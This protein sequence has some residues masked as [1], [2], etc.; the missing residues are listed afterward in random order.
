MGNKLH[1]RS[2]QNLSIV[3]KLEFQLRFEPYG[4]FTSIKSSVTIPRIKFSLYTLCTAYTLC[5]MGAL[6]IINNYKKS[7][8]IFVQIKLFF[9]KIFCFS[10][11]CDAH[12]SF[13]INLKTISLVYAHGDHKILYY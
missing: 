3:P 4:N 1:G 8:I 6:I 10:D 12:K 9:I 11:M 13:I 2:V 5:C 7:R